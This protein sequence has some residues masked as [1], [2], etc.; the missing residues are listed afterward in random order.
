MRD[1]IRLRLHRIAATL[2]LAAAITLTTA[3]AAHASFL[4]YACNGN[5]C[6]IN[7]DGS[8]QRQLTSDGQPGT[9][10]V[11]GG[12]SLSRDGNKLAFAFN[13]HIIVSDPNANNRSAPFATT[14]L[15]AKMRPDGGQVAELEQTFS[16]PAIQVC[17]YNLDGSGRNCP[18][19]TPS[20]GWAPD[21][22]LLISTGAGPPNYNQEICLVPVGGTS[23]PGCDARAND[24]MNDL[25][26][27]AVSPDGSTLAV[28]VGGGVGGSVMGHIALYNY[29]TGQFERNLTA[30]T[31]D[32]T[33]AW[34]PDGTQIAFARGSSIYVIATNRAAGSELQLVAQGTD[35]TWGG[36]ASPPPPPQ[37]VVHLKLTVKASSR[38]HVVK[39]KGLTETVE[40]N[41]ACAFRATGEVQV[42]G[43]VYTA[44]MV[45][46]R[47]HANR[48]K[49]IVLGLSR[50][51]LRAV[52][53]ALAHQD[54][55]AAEVGAVA[56]S[57]SQKKTA[58]VDFLVGH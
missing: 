57:G 17:T 48:S 28:T 44:K 50:S 6:R 35:P 4:V 21:N 38:Q 41:L 12:P 39:R 54:L 16:S 32:Q 14:A 34:S 8:G 1:S 58:A 23:N 52:A 7:A 26:D 37:P 9:S 3:A 18:Y 20:A 56:Q 29:A 33:P 53:K 30:G 40:C 5:L 25:Y 49:T 2:A 15:V 43:K 42:S 36:P 55:V 45:T 24:P 11:Y 13:D 31:T 27:P 47:L 19:G 10:K 46:G 51:V 22:N